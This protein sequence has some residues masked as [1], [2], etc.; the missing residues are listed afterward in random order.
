MYWA[1][2]R[3]KSQPG[4]LSSAQAGRGATRTGGAWHQLRQ[5]HWG[6][7][8]P[9]LLSLKSRCSMANFG[10]AK[11]SM[12]WQDGVRSGQ[13]KLISALSPTGLSAGFLGIQMWRC[14]ARRGWFGRGLAGCGPIGCGN[15][16]FSTE[17]QQT[18][19]AGFIESRHGTARLG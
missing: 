10:M 2:L 4:Q 16:D 12:V 19:P 8:L 3:C 7:R 17:G 18:L 1:S 15:A 13:A 14:L 6:L 11:R 5:Q 9:L